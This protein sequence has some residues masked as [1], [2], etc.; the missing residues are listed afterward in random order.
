MIIKMDIRCHFYGEQFSPKVFEQLTGLSLM[1]KI[2]VGEYLKVGINKG[3]PSDYG[4]GQLCPPIEFEG[5]E[6][7]GFG[8]IA[9]TLSQQIEELYRCGTEKI[10]LVIGVWYD[11]QCNLVFEPESIRLIG[12]LG[13]PL[14]VSCY[15]DY[16]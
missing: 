7:F 9:L 6:D 16:Y 12:E 8:W 11:K 10:D 14:K 13:I 15:E 3:N 4:S 5:N 1:N 2:E